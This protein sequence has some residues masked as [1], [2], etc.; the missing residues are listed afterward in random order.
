MTPTINSIYKIMV[1]HVPEIPPKVNEIVTLS[2]GGGVQERPLCHSLKMSLLGGGGGGS[3]ARVTM[4]FYMTFF[5]FDGIPQLLSQ[6]LVKL[7]SSRIKS[8]LSLKVDPS[9]APACQGS[10]FSQ[11]EQQQEPPPNSSQK[12]RYQKSE[13]GHTDQLTI[14]S[15][16]DKFPRVNE[17]GVGR[18]LPFFWPKNGLT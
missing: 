18:P 1:L 7:Y 3:K 4:S 10:A 5:Y 12:E 13:I 17:N 8:S 9:T 15:C 14:K 11:S 2:G 6:Q 16:E